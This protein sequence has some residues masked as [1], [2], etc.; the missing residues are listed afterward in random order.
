V[1]QLK[2]VIPIILVII[3]VVVIAAI[4]QEMIEP[5]LT[6]EQWRE[7]IDQKYESQPDD[8]TIEK[9]LDEIKD[10]KIQNEQSEKPYVPQG[11]KW[12]NISGPFMIDND[13]YLLGQ[14]VFVNISG[15]DVNDKGSVDVF[16]PVTNQNYMI[17]YSSMKF[18]GSKDLRNNYYFTPKLS[19][20]NAL[21]NSDQL[22][23][24]WVMKFKGTQYPDLIFTVVD[25]KIPGY[26]SLFETIKNNGNC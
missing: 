14:K 5:V 11:P 17:L 18:D 12:N 10:I 22:L 25:K 6:D 9:L 15:L 23:G 20:F 24:D 4:Q 13:E 3:A 1:N 16:L 2:I 26:E 8:P 19:A 21:C 7:E